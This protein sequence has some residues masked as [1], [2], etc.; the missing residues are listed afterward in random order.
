[1]D[2]PVAVV[3]DLKNNVSISRMGQRIRVS[4][5]LARADSAAT[6]SGFRQL[7]SVLDEWFPGA[8][9]HGQTAGAQEWR[10]E[11]VSTPDALPVVGPTRSQGVW[12]NAAHGGHGWAMAC[13]SA[14]LL[15][16][17]L[18]GRPTSVAAGPYSATRWIP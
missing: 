12:I 6:D 1:M 15:A 17:Q 13:G 14:R 9:R 7:Y 8:I 11:V 4:G 16:D 5:P 3:H 2:A 10:T 18:S